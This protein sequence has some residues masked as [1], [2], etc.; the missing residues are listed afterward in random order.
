RLGLGE[1]LLERVAHR[2]P[3]FGVTSSNSRS[4]SNATDGGQFSPC[5]TAYASHARNPTRFLSR[6]SPRV[7]GP[8]SFATFSILAQSM[9]TTGVSRV[10]SIR[11]LLSRFASTSTPGW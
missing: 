8:S 7:L 3:S 5:A 6:T 4:Y 11:N 2:A 10:R 9:V 1:Q